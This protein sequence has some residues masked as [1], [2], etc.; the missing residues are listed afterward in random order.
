MYGNGLMATVPFGRFPFEL[1]A[2]CYSRGMCASI[3]QN[4][5]LAI[6]LLPLVAKRE[7]HKHV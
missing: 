2:H 4:K 1:R 3:R 5:V 7:E 6:K